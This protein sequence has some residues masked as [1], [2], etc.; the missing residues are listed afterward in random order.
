MEVVD[1]I[2]LRKKKEKNYSQQTA[3]GDFGASFEWYR[4]HPHDLLSS[5]VGFDVRTLILSC[6]FRFSSSG[7]SSAF[8]LLLSDRYIVHSFLTAHIH[9]FFHV[10]IPTMQALPDSRQQSFE[11][12][13]GPPENFLEIEVTH[14]QI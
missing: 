4:R 9:Y 10:E 1:A 2:G 14:A 7:R 11:E 8:D 3:N 5:F 12:I 6:W 13:Y